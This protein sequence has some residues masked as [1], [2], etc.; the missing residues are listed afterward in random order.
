MLDND[1]EFRTLLDDANRANVSF[2][3]VDP[4]G[5]PVF[6]TP[7]GPGPPID[8]DRGH[9][10][11]CAAA[12]SRFSTMAFATDGIA[13]VN[14][15]DLDRGLRRIVD[16]LTSYY[17]LGYYSTN[18]K[19][20]G[21]FRKITVR[22]K[23]PGVNVRARRGYRAPSE[24]ELALRSAAGPAAGAGPTPGSDAL[25]TAVSTALGA[26]AL[27]RTDVPVR[28]QVGYPWRRK[29]PASGAP[30]GAGAQLWVTGELDVTRA[31][32]EGWLETA[33]ATVTV[34]D[35]NRRT[36]GSTTLTFSR[37]AR[38]L[39]AVVPEQPTLGPGTYDVRISARSVEGRAAP[40]ES[41]RVTVPALPAGAE[42]L[43]VGQPALSRRGPF[44]GITF[45]PSADPRFRRQ[46]WIRVEVALAGDVERTAARVLDRTGHALGIPVK[47]SSQQTGVSSWVVAE[48]ALAPLAPGDYLVEVEATGRG[49]T[50]RVLAAFRIIP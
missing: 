30:P 1:R 26:L 13:V 33:D 50:E 2:Y 44:T 4:R 14:S 9:R 49:R 43:L 12:S 35:A 7:I 19:P 6:D 11:S 21:R 47:T 31:T 25:A 37:T 22:V 36:V 15:N 24:A 38:G 5:L 17:L 40:T 20:D 27:V 29:D 23:R 10:A 41:F 46:E 16:D 8:V 42:T 32:Q 18:S 48:A 28:Y 45:Q 34:S 39:Q 3:P